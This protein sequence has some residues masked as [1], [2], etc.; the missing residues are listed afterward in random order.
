VHVEVFD[1]D[2][3]VAFELASE[4]AVRLAGAPESCRIEVH[5]ARDLNPLEQAALAAIGPEQR[6]LPPEL[7]DLVDGLDN[8]AVVTCP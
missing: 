2:Y 4:E 5:L 6:E 3:F 1:P 8:T 7:Q